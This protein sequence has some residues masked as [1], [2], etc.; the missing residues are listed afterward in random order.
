VETAD[1]ED[2]PRERPAAATRRQGLHSWLTPLS[3]LLL[4][5]G[6][7]G[8]A[9]GLYGE[10]KPCRGDCAETTEPVTASELF[11]P[12]L[13]AGGALLLL[14]LALLAWLVVRSRKRVPI[15][16]EPSPS[17]EEPVRVCPN[18]STQSRT[19]G[20]FCPHCGASFVRSRGV[21]RPVKAVLLAGSAA[22][23]LAAAGAGTLLYINGVKDEK[24]ERVRLARAYEEQQERK[25]EAQ[26]QQAI[27][28]FEIGSRRDMIREAEDAITKDMQER[29]QE[30]F[31]I[32]EGPILGTQC[33]PEPGTD[34]EDVSVTSANLDCL[35]Y[36]EQRGDRLSGTSVSATVNFETG[37]FTWQLGEG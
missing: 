35:A 33:E 11:L 30:E 8:L 14:G 26:A 29:S 7:A 15:P 34:I 2:T 4:A 32:V 21:S 31:A 36:N 16:A 1:V 27:E 20:Q 19:T 18:C 37:E 12:P 9:I 23:C 6:A 5:A 22:L 24:E 25:Q 28:E 10:L 13:A 17:G 3:F